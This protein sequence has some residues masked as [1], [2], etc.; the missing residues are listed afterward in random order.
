MIDHK[1]LIDKLNTFPAMERQ[2]RA[3]LKAGIMED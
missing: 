1:A 3:W 2:R